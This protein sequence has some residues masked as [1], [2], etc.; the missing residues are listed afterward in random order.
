[1][2]FR[3]LFLVFLKALLTSLCGFLLL[4]SCCSALLA[5]PTDVL[6]GKSSVW[7]L[8]FPQT[9]MEQQE[10]G[11]CCCRSL[12]IIWFV[13][14][15][16]AV[17]SWISFCCGVSHFLLRHLQFWLGWLTIQRPFTMIWC[18]SAAWSGSSHQRHLLLRS[19]LLPLQKAISD[20]SNDFYWNACDEFVLF[21]S[22]KS[23][24]NFEVYV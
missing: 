5:A 18:S 12:S 11:H 17:M 21:L 23:C 4:F 20:N 1:M 3:L 6:S 19:G 9:R 22:L 7:S 8:V 15:P 14:F 16:V 13:P 2:V 10:T 24:F